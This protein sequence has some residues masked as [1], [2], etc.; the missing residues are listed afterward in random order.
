MA[1]IDTNRGAKRAREARAALGLDPAG[2]LR[3]LLT[4][5]EEDAGLPVVVAALP[6]ELAGACYRDGAGAI[7]WVNGSPEQAHQ[8]QRFTL[9]HELGHAWCGHN[10]A[11]EIDTF[12][13]LNGKTTNPLEIQANAFAAE[14][15]VPA[16]AM[17]ELIAGDPTLEEVVLISSAFGVSA[18]MV[19]YRLKLLRLAS[20]G[21]IERLEEEVEEGLHFGV[22]DR[23][24]LRPFADRLGAIRELPYLSP[25]LEDTALGAALRGTAPAD[26]GIAGAIDRLLA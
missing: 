5:V 6:G 26:A 21:Q 19:V 20:E 17:E 22:R 7:L 10:G 12:A 25:A 23:L 18:I 13:T 14:F 4:V 15:L 11:L 24:R 16:A 2:P 1:R 9:A 3:C 8:R